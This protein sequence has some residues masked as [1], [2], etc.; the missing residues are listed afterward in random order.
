MINNNHIE[1]CNALVYKKP[2]VKYVNMINNNHIERCNALVYK[3]PAVKYVNMINNN[4]IER[5]SLRFFT[6]SSLCHTLS[7][8]RLLK[9]RGRSHVLQ[10]MCNTSGAQ[11]KQHVRCHSVQRTAQLLHL[12]ELKSPLFYWLKP[13]TGDF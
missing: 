8:T 9:W 12:T 7:P 11:H 4:H 6:F 1:R 10:I 13:L 5:C 2:A 3:K